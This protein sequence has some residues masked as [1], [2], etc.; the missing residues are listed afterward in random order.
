MD[1]IT[2]IN[3]IEHAARRAAEHFPGKPTDSVGFLDSARWGAIQCSAI[4]ALRRALGVPRLPEHLY[5]FCCE[6]ADDTY[7]FPGWES[8]WERARRELA[9]KLA[10]LG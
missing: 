4:R 6:Y 8:T 9:Q 3:R 7:L 5:V 10:E 1:S 2:I